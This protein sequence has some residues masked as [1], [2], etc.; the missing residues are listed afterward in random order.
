M[1]KYKYETHMH[2][3]ETSGCARN[4]GAEMAEFYARLGYAGVVVTDHVI[5]HPRHAESD[6]AWAAYCEH[7]TAGYRACLERGRQLGLD[8]F[9]GWEYS[10][11]VAHFLVFGLPPEWHRDK[12]E[13]VSWDARTYL[14]RVRND[15][16]YVVH[17]H[18]FRENSE[19][20]WLYPSLTDGCEVLSAAR[21]DIA[22]V[23]AG[24]Y[25]RSYGLAAVAG[26][27]CHSI[28]MP[29][30]CGVLSERRLESIEDFISLLKGG[31]ELFDD[32]L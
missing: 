17:A 28:N 12:P 8:V 16:A 31:A 19:P 1:S 30:L 26:S 32:T 9:Y 18:P 11:S 4:T 13:S 10:S 20:I 14:E 6:E 15:G 3:S 25:A 29:R 27:D 23:R 24:E 22:N 2:C 21:A 7:I 5:P